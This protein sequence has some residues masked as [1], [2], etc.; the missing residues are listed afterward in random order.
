MIFRSLRP[1]LNRKGAAV[2][3]RSSPPNSLPSVLL[4]DP[5]RIRKKN[6][7]PNDQQ[8]VRGKILQ[9]HPSLNGLWGAP[10]RILL[11]SKPPKASFWLR[12]SGGNLSLVSLYSSMIWEIFNADLI[13]LV[14]RAELETQKDFLRML[15]QCGAEPHEAPAQAGTQAEADGPGW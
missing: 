15:R 8:G 13:A 5:G 12:T 9:R 14:A 3:E 7:S 10:E 11:E 1:S 6:P 2:R 4:D